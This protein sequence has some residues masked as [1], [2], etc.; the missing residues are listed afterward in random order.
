MINRFICAPFLNG[1]GISLGCI[2]ERGSH[3]V[4]SDAICMPRQRHTCRRQFGSLAWSDIGCPATFSDR[5]ISRTQIQ[6]FIDTLPATSKRR[7]S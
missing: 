1:S 3:E 6:R 2:R 5:T 7:Q 4:P